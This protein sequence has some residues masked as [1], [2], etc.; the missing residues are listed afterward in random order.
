[1]SN[2]VAPANRNAIAF[3]FASPIVGLT[4]ALL[5][6]M[7]VSDL[8][9]T[10]DVWMGVVIIA[11]IGAAQVVGGHFSAIAMRDAGSHKGAPKAAAVLNLVVVS[12]WS[13]VTFFTS[14]SGGIGAVM[15]INAW[16]ERTQKQELRA[17]NSDDFWNHL[18]P[19][20]VMFLTLL[21]VLY[22]FIVLRSKGSKN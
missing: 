7:A 8:F 22:F 3:G 1:M 18:L 20:Q 4:L 9:G 6:G 17:F 10:L 12:I 16:N 5:I 15:A 19:A 21:V 14:V 11:I 2:P 13:Y